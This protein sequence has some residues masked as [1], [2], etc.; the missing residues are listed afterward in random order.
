[1]R[2]SLART[3]VAG[4]HECNQ[5]KVVNEEVGSETH[6]GGAHN[7]MIEISMQLMTPR[8]VQEKHPFNTDDGKTQYGSILAPTYSGKIIK[9]SYVY[10]LRVW[11][12]AS[13][14]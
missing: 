7:E 8:D 14:G 5:I 9:V 3:V 2:L 4:Q 10:E 11:H 1:M 13:F 12:H 6:S